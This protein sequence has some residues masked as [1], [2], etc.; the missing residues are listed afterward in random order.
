MKTALSHIAE[1]PDISEV[2]DVSH[3]SASKVSY[4]GVKVGKITKISAEHRPYVYFTDADK[5]GVVARY[6]HSLDWQVIVNA[7]EKQIDVLLVFEN[8]DPNKPI[9]IDTLGPSA[10]SSAVPDEPQQHEVTI[11]GETITFDAKEQLTLKCGKAS[12]TLTKAG[13]IMLKGAYVLNRS[14]GALRIKGGSVQI[15]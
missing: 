13:K 10:D 3:I 2:S 5:E 15:N 9:I 4:D 11:D 6:A 14:S 12:V 7:L 8:G 1:I